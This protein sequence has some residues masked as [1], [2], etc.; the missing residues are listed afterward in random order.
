MQTLSL[1]D[2]DTFYAPASDECW[3]ILAKEIMASY[4]LSYINQV[5]YNAYSQ[6][7]YDK[8][9]NHK[10]K[11]EFKTSIELMKAKPYP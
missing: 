6:S 8:I 3:V 10:Y 7:E 2:K 4:T 9:D 5:V 11:D 1:T